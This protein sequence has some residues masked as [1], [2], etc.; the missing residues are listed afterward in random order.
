MVHFERR[1]NNL[2]SYVALH[3]E[4]QPFVYIGL[5]DITFFVVSTGCIYNRF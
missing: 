4:G 1:V 2:P 3:F 5:F